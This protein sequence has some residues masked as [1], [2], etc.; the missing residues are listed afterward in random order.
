MAK[1]EVTV[2]RSLIFVGLLIG[3]IQTLYGQESELKSLE[4]EYRAVLGLRDPGQRQRAATRG[5]Q[6]AMASAVNAIKTNAALEQK[7][8]LSWV[9]TEFGRLALKPDAPDRFMISL[10]SLGMQNQL[11][12][13]PRA[14]SLSTELQQTLE[15]HPELNQLSLGGKPAGRILA[16]ES[17]KVE[18]LSA[19]AGKVDNSSADRLQ[20]LVLKFLAEEP[21]SVVLAE[22]STLE[23]FLGESLLLAIRDQQDYEPLIRNRVSTQ[24]RRLAQANIPFELSSCLFR[25]LGTEAWR[26]REFT[27][28]AN[29]LEEM[30]PSVDHKNLPITCRMSFLTQ[31]GYLAISQLSF[32]DALDDFQQSL[33]L[34]DDKKLWGNES[35]RQQH[36]TMAMNNLGYLCSHRGDDRSAE[37][38]FRRSISISDQTN[39]SRELKN[40]SQ[41]SRLNLATILNRKNRL[42]VSE[43]PQEILETLLK[44]TEGLTGKSVPQLSVRSMVLAELG[45]MAYRRG[46]LQAS[47]DFF[48]KADSTNESIS[49]VENDTTADLLVNQAWIASDRGRY[50]DA[51]RMFQDAWQI[52]RRIHGPLGLRTI[53]YEAYLALSRMR[54][55]KTEEAAAHFSQALDARR[56]LVRLI[57][58]QPMTKREQ[59]AWIQELR[60]HNESV[61][62]P[63][64]LDAFIQCTKELAVPAKDQYQRVLEWKGLFS[65]ANKPIADDELNQRRT[66]VL[67]AL[68]SSAI[69]RLTRQSAGDQAAGTVNLRKELEDI[70]RELANANTKFDFSSPTP[71]LLSHSLPKNTAFLDVVELKFHAPIKSVL[72]SGLDR[73]YVGFLTLPTGEVRRIE[74]GE[75]GKRKE[76]DA[77]VRDAYQQ[78]TS[79]KDLMDLD[80]AKIRAFLRDPIERQLSNDIKVL[81]FCGD[82]LLL[83]L[84][85]GVIP[86]QDGAPWIERLAFG[87]VSNANQFIARR[88][89]NLSRRA[90]SPR[91]LVGDVDYGPA[92][93]G[94]RALWERLPD[95]RGEII[96][97]MRSLSPAGTGSSQTLIGR[98]AEEQ[99][100][101]R[102][103]SSAKLVHLATHGYFAEDAV[104]RRA[105]FKTFDYLDQLDS[106]I[107]L[108]KANQPTRDASND[109]YLTASELYDMDLSSVQHFA[110]SACE[111]GLGHISEGQGLIGVLDAI[112]TAGARTIV[113]ALWEVPSKSSAHLMAQYYQLLLHPLQPLGPA[114]AMRRTQ[115]AMYRGEIAGVDGEAYTSPTDWASWI[116]TGDAH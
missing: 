51:A 113:S 14:V 48:A 105:A 108:A 27:T 96:A 95:T 22:F 69:H 20:D 101:R 62:M 42:V 3:P 61:T 5:F 33:A 81:I 58:S 9:A 7:T 66:A 4:S 43:E 100:V 93:D 24:R 114:E 34:A 63:G 11:G 91:V 23:E 82:G 15:K 2:I 79:G 45:N 74:F 46:D 83:R 72:Q 109:G 85:L 13:D 35:V 112:E 1:S 86:D 57:M 31:K 59:L 68:R 25:W 47:Q 8:Q 12:F 80:L 75:S 87:T 40:Q 71:E 28:L 92:V 78:L 54:E 76:I 39:I 110:L 99:E 116:V 84:P 16:I 67:N 32:V 30:K 102:S 107:V 19:R 89:G 50:A 44:E 49:Q 17:M 115:L 52:H 70:E 37:D 73:R 6:R 38:W 106:A 94:K 64:A 90:G 111:T 29:S 98:K 41:L 10:L 97:L 56:D 53:E 18:V 36:L 103:I 26:R 60:A 104:T 65:W 55:G 21:K 88:R 77:V